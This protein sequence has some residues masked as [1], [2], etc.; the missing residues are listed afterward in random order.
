M[1]DPSGVGMRT[2]IVPMDV[3][4]P[5]P[6]RKDAF[7]G[8]RQNVVPVYAQYAFAWRYPITHRSASMH[9]ECGAFAA[10]S[11]SSIVAQ[12]QYVA[13]ERNNLI[14]FQR[15]CGSALSTAYAFQLS[16]LKVGFSL[17]WGGRRR[18][19]LPLKNQPRHVHFW[20]I[21]AHHR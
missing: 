2:G 11:L 12:V 19:V 9:L 14:C 21:G 1:K 18:C 20:W 4:E 7:N 3:W 17:R 13:Q 6:K 15:V 16:A 5:S 8:R 10:F